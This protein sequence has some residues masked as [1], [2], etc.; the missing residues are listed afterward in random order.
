[1]DSSVFDNSIRI[2]DLS[3]SKGNASLDRLT[4]WLIAC[5]IIVVIGL[6][7]EYHEDIKEFFTGRPRTRRKWK[8]SFMGGVLVILG[9]IGELAVTFFAHRVELKVRFDNQEIE[10]LLS[11]KAGSAAGAA[12]RANDSA[13]QAENLAHAARQEADSAESHLV[14]ALK[15]AVA[16]QEELDRLKVWRSLPHDS[17][18]VSALETFKGTEYI[19]FVSVRI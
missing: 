9:I 16:L 14:Q 12:K 17:E 10:W 8:L 18:L 6:F 4:G 1:M 3:V 5:N 15:Q 7:V 2:L 19:F 13:R 11:A